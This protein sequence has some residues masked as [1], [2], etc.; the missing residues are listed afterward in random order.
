MKCS[1]RIGI[2]DLQEEF[3]YRGA[4]ALHAIVRVVR[5]TCEE[6]SGRAPS[7]QEELDMK[8]CKTGADERRNAGRRRFLG[9]PRE[10]SLCQCPHR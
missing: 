5:L 3:W 2:E 4:V 10:G 7:S 6:K 9:L 8:V 1:F